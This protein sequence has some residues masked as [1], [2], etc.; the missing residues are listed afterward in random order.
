MREMV[1]KVCPDQLPYRTSLAESSQSTGN[2]RWIH[3]GPR[4]WNLHHNQDDEV[5]Q[6][7]FIVIR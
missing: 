1:K 7:R 6:V 2:K 5:I 3:A 4:L